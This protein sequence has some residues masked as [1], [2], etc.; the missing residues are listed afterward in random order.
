MSSTM[1]G[2]AG[3]PAAPGS[4]SSL[5]TVPSQPQPAELAP[6]EVQSAQ[7]QA[8]QPMQLGQV[9][10]VLKR[11]RAVNAR[12]AD[13]WL[14]LAG[15]LAGALGLVW[16]SYDRLL[17][18]S[19]PVGFFI[20]WYAVFLLVYAAVSAM[21][22]PRQIVIDRLAA[23]VVYGGAVIVFAAV[24]ATII[25][26]F[27]RGWA[28]DHHVNFWTQTMGSTDPTAPLTQ[29]G[30]L[31][32]MV[33]TLW[34]I[35]IAI[36]VSLPLGVGTAV[37]IT[38]V[39]GRFS[40]AVRTVVEAMTAM[41]DILAGLFIYTVLIVRLGVQQSGFAAGVALSVMMLPIIARSAEVTLRVVPGGLREASLALGASRWRTVW[42][43]V[44]PTARS[45]LATALILGI[46]RGI[47][48]TAPVLI[49][50]GESNY[51][52]LN[53]L[54]EPMNSLPLFIYQ[55]IQSG[56]NEMIARAWGAASVLLAVILILFV[57]ARLLARTGPGRP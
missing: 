15:S 17:P 21:A 14:A 32:A 1:S 4:G 20:C 13:E 49:A 56:L 8:A 47:G 10:Y 42:R 7:S 51:M 18:F 6:A 52:N 29:G 34:E 33:G 24:L 43:V 36:V 45:G 38:E 30:M 44:L 41:P 35:A 48:E 5:Q 54:H 53:P 25:Y 2:P 11:P 19:G 12:T 39:G 9:G 31:H 28:A 37:F 16:V 57:T 40:H 46:A 26:T 23:A 27:I 55:G 50:S 3:A 22:H